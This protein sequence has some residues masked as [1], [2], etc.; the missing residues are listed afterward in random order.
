M[1]SLPSS[2][3]RLTIARFLYIYYEELEDKSP[4]F[5]I[6]EGPRQSCPI[7]SFNRLKIILKEIFEETWADWALAKIK[8][9][10]VILLC[11]KMVLLFYIF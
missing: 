9:L 6:K 8:K 4:N 7:P 10:L 11:I 2:I 5:K 3:S 1:R